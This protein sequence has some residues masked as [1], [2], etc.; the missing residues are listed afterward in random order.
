MRFNNNM[1][2][3]LSIAL[4][5]GACSDSSTGGGGGG[6][7]GGGATSDS[8]HAFSFDEDSQTYLVGGHEVALADVQR[9]LVG[10]LC[11]KCHP[12]AVP[13]VKDSVHFN[14]AAATPR[15]MFPGGG[16]HGMIDRACGLPGTTGLTNSFTD[17]NL[18]ECAKCHVGRYLPMME[19]M[20]SG[21]FTQMG[22]ADPAGQAE[23]LVNAGID[24]LICHAETYR[25]WPEDGT[26]ASLA[27]TA[28]PDGASPTPTGS[29]R[30]AR[31]DGDFDRDGVPD[32]VIDV[33]GDG[34]PDA[35]LMMDT[36]G[37]GVPETRWPT[38]AQDRS[39]AALASIGPTTEHTCLRCHEHARTGYKRGTMFIEGRDVHST[40]TT[41]PFAGAENRCTVCHTERDHK[42]IRGHSVGGDLAAADYMPPAPGLPVDPDDAFDVS[43]VKC[44][45]GIGKFGDNYHRPSHLEAMSCET[46]HIPYG[47]GLTYSLFGH[48]GQ[49][50]FARNDEGKDTRLVVADMYINEGGSD[51]EADLD[52]YKTPPVLMWFDGGSSFLAQPL[53]AR[54]MPNA[55]ITPFKPMAN[56]MVFD[57]RFFDGVMLN[58]DAGAPYN[59]HSMYRFYAEGANAEAFSALG[60]LATPPTDTRKVT[61][62]DFGSPDPDLQ[63]MALMQIFPNLVYFDKGTFGYE[64]YLT[65]TGS[66]LDANGDGLVDSGQSMLGDM[67]VAANA[68]LAQFQAFNRPMGF[69]DGYEWYPPYDD[70]SDVI[71]MKLPDGSLIKMFLQMQAAGLPPEQQGPFMEA[72]ENYPSFSAI[73]LGG[74]GVAPKEEAL[75]AAPFSCLDCHGSD[76]V[77]A[78]PVP[79]GRK[80]PVNM[81]PMGVLEMPIYAWRYYQVEQLVDLGLA[82]SSE[83]VLSGAVDVDI[84]GDTNFLRVSDTE[85]VLNW[86]APNAPDGYRPADDPAALAGTNL[87][88]ADLT[89][90][91]GPWMP[92]LEPVVDYVPNYEVLGYQASEILWP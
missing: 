53:A 87:G 23:Q 8:V 35:P 18:G 92:V 19:G 39:P 3:V 81:G 59:A 14:L 89:W 37:D 56:G 60:M 58:N 42:F 11:S 50:S 1:V 54:G 44:H 34:T 25:S 33:D 43:C 70:V 66:A 82:T 86:F 75:G 30:V 24:C 20:F 64:H 49:V 12:N 90:N 65:R 36:D 16:A 73:T 9:D 15:V 61:L 48:G 63:A 62:A 68:G 77:F 71:S 17:V 5:L 51:I 22:V 45:D 91:G 52:A 74:H 27:G 76:G 21:M 26:L 78:R 88:V 72:I 6:G 84:D 67:L 29:A 32:L 83:E 2:W 38:V 7:G 57:A 41:G 10:T 47:S 80:L 28:P 55:K 46:C 31:D 79:V 40:A 85:L 4:L 13:E 69:P